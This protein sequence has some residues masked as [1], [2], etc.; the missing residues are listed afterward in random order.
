M[1]RLCWWVFA[2][3]LTGVPPWCAAEELVRAATAGAEI[4]VS[5]SGHILSFSQP[6]GRNL[7]WQHPA[8]AAH[9]VGGWVNHGGDKLWLWPQ[10][11]WEELSGAAWPPPAQAEGWLITVSGGRVRMESPR[12]TQPDV[13]FVREIELDPHEPACRITNRMSQAVG[14]RGGM[15]LWM[16]TQLPTP[17]A[18]HAPA[19]TRGHAVSGRAP[20]NQDT[21]DDG[22]LR[23]TPGPGKSKLGLDAAVLTAVYADGRLEMR[24]E[25]AADGVWGPGERAQVYGEAAGS[26]DLP[27]GCPGYVEAEFT[28]PLADR[29]PLPGLDV[30]WRWTRR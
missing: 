11:R 9:P 20:W 22:T 7:L 26:A 23:L 17:L 13:S 27:S 14:G 21:E 18:I 2:L 16:V 4:T 30:T 28:A 25:S 29:E 19:G 12:M 3:V 10:Q 1:S 8:A 24:A 15:A 5:T 6:G